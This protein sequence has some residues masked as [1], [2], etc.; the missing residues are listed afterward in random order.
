MAERPVTRGRDSMDR[1]PSRSAIMERPD[2]RHSS[3]FGDR[4]TTRMVRLW[5]HSKGGY[6]K[7][8]HK[9]ITKQDSH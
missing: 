5:G 4:P 7:M 9:A 6:G 2:T 3:A 1:P 8:P